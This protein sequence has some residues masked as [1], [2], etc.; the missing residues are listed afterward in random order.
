V[1]SFGE[2]S[3]GEVTCGNEYSFSGRAQR[4]PKVVDVWAAYGVPPS[5][6]LG[7]YVS[8]CKEL[9]IFLYISIV[10]YSTVS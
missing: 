6:D 2:G 10:V 8:S 7:L 1:P 4:S 3:S 5:L 9:A